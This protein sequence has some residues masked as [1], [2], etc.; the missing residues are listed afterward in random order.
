MERPNT[1]HPWLAKGGVSGDRYDAKFQDL[2]ASG[3]NV[4]GEADLVASF[5]PLSVLDAGCGTG[6]VAIELARRGI[7]VVGVDLDA[8]MLEAARRKAPQLEWHHADLASVDLVRRFDV[9]VLA[10]NV[11]VFLEPGTEKHVVSNMARHLEPG[12]VLVAGFQLRPGRPEVTRIMPGS[13]SFDLASYDALASAAGLTLSE[14]WS[15]WSRDPFVPDGGYAVS[16]HRVGA[17][18]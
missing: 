17:S 9:V 13:N 12:G 6:R 2:A 5:H 4:H 7:E 3:A 14:R 10:G 16:I 1:R 15:T 11:M 18:P 8:H